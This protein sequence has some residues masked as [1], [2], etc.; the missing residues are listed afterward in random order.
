MSIDFRRASHVWFF[1][2]FL[3]VLSYGIG[4]EFVHLFPHLP[5]WVEG[6]SPLT[7][8]GLLFN[9]FDKAAWHWPIFRALGIVSVPDLRGR[10][11][12]K[13]ISSYVGQNDEHLTS[14][15]IME[16]AQTFSGIQVDVYYRR[17]SSKTSAT[18]F[19]QIDGIQ[20]LLTMFDAE[21]KVNYE[22]PDGNSLRGVSKLATMPDG[23]LQGTYFNAAGRHGELAFQRTGYKL[24]HTFDALDSAR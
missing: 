16:V 13:Q 15:V 20:T 22:E 6:I 8:Y 9:F 14:R 10:W 2:A 1:A 7:A 21:R 11:L 23:T 5:F 17:W 18:Q 19:V 4:W 12:G 24:A 3:P